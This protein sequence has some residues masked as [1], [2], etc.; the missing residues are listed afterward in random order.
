MKTL[1]PFIFFSNMVGI[2]YLPAQSILPSNPFTF[3]CP[4]VS[5]P[6]FQP[7]GQVWKSPDFSAETEVYTTFFARAAAAEMSHEKNNWNHP[8]KFRERGWLYSRCPVS[9]VHRVRPAL[10]KEADDVPCFN[11]DEEVRHTFLAEIDMAS[12]GKKK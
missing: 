3:Y 12:F 5:H 11:Y 10:K 9:V 6:G 7:A 8:R 4:C 2:S 1:L